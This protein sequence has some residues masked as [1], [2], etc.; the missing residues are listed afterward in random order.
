MSGQTCGCAVLCKQVELQPSRAVFWQMTVPAVGRSK[1][2]RCQTWLEKK[3]KN[4]GRNKV[5]KPV[6]CYLMCVHKDISP[7]HCVLFSSMFVQKVGPE[8]LGAS[9][10]VR[11]ISEAERHSI[12]PSSS[13]C[14]ILSLCLRLFIFNTVLNRKMFFKSSPHAC[15]LLF[16][17]HFTK[18]KFNDSSWIE[19]GN[20]QKLTAKDSK[21]TTACK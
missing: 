18:L 21:I 7:K 5:Q 6:L 2:D 17:S 20:V 4:W 1:M 9:F 11:C 8:G 16:S 13:S 15:L 19:D 12:R 3:S 10:P 14:F